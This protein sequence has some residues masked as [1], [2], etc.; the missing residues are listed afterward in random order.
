VRL[1]VDTNVLIAGLVA[2]GLCRDI[3]K[4]RLPACELFTSR[5]LLDELAEILR[6]KFDTRSQDLPLL[7]VYEAEATIVRPK[8]LP[9]PICRDT[10]DDEVLAAAVVARAEI[11]L[12]GDDDLLALEEFQGVRIL[13]PRKFVQWMDQISA[14]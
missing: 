9:K 13:S 4:R 12:T 6:E 7:Q 11:I 10:D 8:P 1:V 5:A 3:V 2:D 14:A